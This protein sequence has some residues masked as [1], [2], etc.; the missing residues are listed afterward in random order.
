MKTEPTAEHHWLRALVGEWAFETEA[1]M[2]PD[3][4]PH[5]STGRET[6]RPLGELWVRCEWASDSAQGPGDSVMT[7]GYDPA[8]GRF[9]GSFVSGMM[10]YQ[11]VYGG[12]L[13]AAKRVLTLETTGPSFTAPGQL[14]PYRDVIELTSDSAR[15]LTSYLHT[16]DGSWQPFMTMR[17]QRV[18]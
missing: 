2:G 14:V 13:D 9:V 18:G 12:T 15:T 16:P 1:N 7:L 6:I 10:A 8:A 5:T 3:Q 17:C 4:P 11:W